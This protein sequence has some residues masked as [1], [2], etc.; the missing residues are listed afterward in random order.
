MLLDLAPTT[1]LNTL[2]LRVIDL[3]STPCVLEL[4][5]SVKCLEFIGYSLFTTKYAGY[6]SHKLPSLTEVTLGLPCL[7]GAVGTCREHAE[8]SS[9]AYV[10][11]LPDSLRHLRV[12]EHFMKSL[13]D[14]SAQTCLRRCTGLEHLTLLA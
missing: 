3:C 12:I 5:S 9:L 7:C 2:S 11:I 14:S 8:F 1:C 6:I 10:P 13:L 4:P